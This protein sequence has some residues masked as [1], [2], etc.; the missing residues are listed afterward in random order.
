MHC[1]SR[2]RL[3]RC[4]GHRYDPGAQHVQRMQPNACA[5]A[6]VVVTSAL[7]A[8]SGCSLAGVVHRRLQVSGL[9]RPPVNLLPSCGTVQPPQNLVTLVT[10]PPWCHQSCCFTVQAQ[11]AAPRQV[12][13]TG[14]ASAAWRAPAPQ[15]TARPPPC[16]ASGRRQHNGTV[17]VRRVQQEI[18]RNS[19]REDIM[20]CSDCVTGHIFYAVGSDFSPAP[21]GSRSSLWGLRFRI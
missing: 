8:S 14:A 12:G 13:G 3:T 20:H 5:P 18:I 16:A 10:K 19:I 6:V 4:I 9:L 2:R 15:S 1:Y 7:A 11:A 17:R 21:G